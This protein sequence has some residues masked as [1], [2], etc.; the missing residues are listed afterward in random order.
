MQI[1]FD[2]QESVDYCGLVTVD[3]HLTSGRWRRSYAGR[4]QLQT[5]RW[6]ASSGAFA[7]S[8]QEHFLDATKAPARGGRVRIPTGDAIT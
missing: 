1:R 7:A 6:R 5:E 2:V 4:S 3:C 8:Q